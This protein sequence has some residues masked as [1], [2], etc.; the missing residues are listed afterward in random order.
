MASDR[1]GAPN[2]L[3]ADKP[4]S[5]RFPTRLASKSPQNA[6]QDGRFLSR[7]VEMQETVDEHQS[8]NHPDRS[9]LKPTVP[10]VVRK[11]LEAIRD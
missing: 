9:A 11:I 6:G 1:D 4:F 3:A 2:E 8:I 5:F 10:T 7:R